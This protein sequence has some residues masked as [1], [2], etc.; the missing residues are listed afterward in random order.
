MLEIKCEEITNGG[1]VGVR[2]E[3]LT[4]YL[5][6]LSPEISEYNHRKIFVATH[7]DL[8][9]HGCKIYIEISRHTIECNVV[10][11]RLRW[12]GGSVLAF[13][14]QVR[15][16]KPGRS[17]RIFRAKKSSSRLSSEGK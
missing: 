16:F 1:S 7:E 3:T 13:G 10:C 8:N 17:H 6:T 15:W 12:S 2:K 5:M 9:F 4:L 11:K 14:T